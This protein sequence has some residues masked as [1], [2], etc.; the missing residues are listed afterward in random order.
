M[1]ALVG[2]FVHTMS[3]SRLVEKIVNLK[4]KLAF[5]N[6]FLQEAEKSSNE[7]SFNK[8]TRI[9]P[10]TKRGLE[11]LLDLVTET[12]KQKDEIIKKALN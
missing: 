7:Y 3:L 2:M 8:F 10:N 6:A 5:Q 12:Q 4:N 11:A 1:Q 9:I